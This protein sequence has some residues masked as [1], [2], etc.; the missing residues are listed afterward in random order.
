MSGLAF[1]HAVAA[2]LRYNGIT[3]RFHPG[4]ERRGNGQSFPAAGPDGSLTHHTGGAYDG[5]LSLLVDG[6]R[7]LS[8]P[9][10]NQCTYADG[11]VTIIA[12]NPANHAGAAG[13]SWA[14]P[15]PDT[16]N[17]NRL[18]W[19]NEVMFPGTEPWTA[20]QYR[21]ARVTAAVVVAIR[22]RGVEWARAHYETSVTGKWDPGIGN[23]RHEWF[24]FDRFRTEIPAALTVPAPAPPPAPATRKGLPDMIERPLV[25]GP[26]YL[27]IACPCG[28][29]SRLVDRQ[30]VSVTAQGGIVKAAVAF[31]RN[32]D[33]DAAPPG[34]GP[35][36]NFTAL[37][38]H[39]RWRE[40][41]SG[42]EYIE[43][44][45]DTEGPGSL[46]IESQPR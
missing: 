30:W 22:K 8:G 10:C 37:N 18:V 1:A 34:A 39:R 9:L 15:F 6:R 5:G 33:T 25:K 38:A 14:R 17:F 12:A 7:D 46:L 44:W 26:N 20:A 28:A 24:P 13:G 36:W 31:Q 42:T 35:I 16:R 4:Y 27:R 11:S 3:V 29:A 32:A 2:G 41:P 43:A 40:M 23:G 45:I 21:T 19:G